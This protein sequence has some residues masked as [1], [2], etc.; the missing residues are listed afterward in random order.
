MASGV[1][2]DRPKKSNW[3]ARTMEAKKRTILVI[4]ATGAQGGSVAR[5][6]LARG[7]FGVRCLTRHPDSDM[8]AALR[9]AGA[10]VVRGDLDAPETLHPALKGCYGVYGVTNFWEHFEKEYDQGKNLIDAVAKAGITH[11]VFSTLP[12]CKKISGGKLEV[13]H[14]DLKAQLEEY[15]RSLK[16][17]ATFVHIAFYFDNFLFFLPPKKQ[18]DGTFAIGFPQG[19]VP[20]AGV[21]VEDVGSIVAPIFERPDEYLGKVVG[22]V[23]DDLTGDQYAEKMTRILGTKVVY[24]HVP[25]EVFAS[26]GFPG[27]DDLANMF[28]FNRLYI[29]NRQ[30]DLKTCRALNPKMQSFESWLKSH[31][32]VFHKVLGQAHAATH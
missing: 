21:A 25:R 26:F 22:I 28:E 15:V 12:P 20:L 10:D 32:A 30:A 8:A 16:L 13:P 24:N 11:F 18:G 6:L 9:K 31:K 2:A 4:G 17:N 23:G 1:C 5:R 14:F 29:P 7:K 19:D 27:A 3:R